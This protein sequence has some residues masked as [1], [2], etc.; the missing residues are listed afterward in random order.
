LSAAKQRIVD[1]D[2]SDEESS[3]SQGGN[4]SESDAADDGGVEVAAPKPTSR[5]ANLQSLIKPARMT[6]CPSV[7]IE[8]STFSSAAKTPQRPVRG[9]GCHFLLQAHAL[10][11]TSALQLA[12]KLR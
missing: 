1:S 2:E 3:S 11:Q 8:D 7:S 9:E 12:C 4:S 10:L 5:T 6:R